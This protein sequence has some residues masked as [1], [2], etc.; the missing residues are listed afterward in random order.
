[1]NSAEYDCVIVGA[2]PAGL[3]ASMYLGRFRLSVAVIDSG[4]SRAAS[5]P[6]SRNQPGFPDGIG[7]ADLLSR[8]RL[9]A[10]RYGAEVHD[11]TVTGLSNAAGGFRART[12][13]GKEFQSETL[14]LATGVANRRPRMPDDLHDQAVARG[15]IRYCPVCDGYEITDLPIAVIGTGEHGIQEATFL[16]A[17]TSEVTLIAPDTAHTFTTE[18]RRHLAESGIRVRNGP[19]SE[20]RLHE[21]AIEIYLPEESLRFASI[22]PAL[23]SDIHSTL[24]ADLGAAVSNEGCLQVDKHQRT[25]VPGLYAAGDVVLGLDQICHATGEGAVAATTI[26][27]DLAVIRERLR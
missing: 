11:G 2:G 17:Y 20:F 23:G 27:N 18:Q 22:Y 9:H 7:G 15:L 10:R 14:L 3:T 24:A 21:D 13:D 19:Y 16:R 8:M 1:V 6:K 12:A 26:R 4:H 5:I 25:S